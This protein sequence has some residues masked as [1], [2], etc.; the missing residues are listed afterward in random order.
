[1]L[2]ELYVVLKQVKCFFDSTFSFAL[3]R[4]GHIDVC[5]LGGLQVD[6]KANIANWMVPN[7]IV[8]GMGGAMDLV[9]GS[10]KVIIGMEHYTKDGEPKIVDKCDL[11]LTAVNKVNTIITEL[12]VFQFIDKV[13]YLTEIS[14]N[15]TIEI[16]KSKTSAKF[17]VSSDLKIM[18]I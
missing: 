9:T 2:V 5:V 1:M 16:V 11:P 17:E 12:A 15:T 4:G 6:E 18:Q 3:I 14:P 13:L 10:K 7:K 8:P